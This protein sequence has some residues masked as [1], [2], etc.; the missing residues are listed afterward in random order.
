MNPT[1]P[2]YI[3]RAP[4]TLNRG[5]VVVVTGS[6]KNNN[7]YAARVNTDKY[8]LIVKENTYYSLVTTGT[9]DN[10]ADLNTEINKYI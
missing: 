9:Y 6:T 2:K 5:E 7:I 3:D 8:Q 1:N 4:A 10:L